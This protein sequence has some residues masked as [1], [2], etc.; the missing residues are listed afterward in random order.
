MQAISE[1]AITYT[2]EF[3]RHL[4]AENEKSKLPRKIFENAGLDVELIGIKRIEIQENVGDLLIVTK[5]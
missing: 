4:I 5:V 3:K 2:D 1:K